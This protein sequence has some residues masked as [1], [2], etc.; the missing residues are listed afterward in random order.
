[1]RFNHR[2]LG[3]AVA[4]A[5]AQA[6]ASA[7]T[8]LYVQAPQSGA[9]YTS[10]VYN[11]PGDPGF[12]WSLPMD[13]EAWAYFR[14]PSSGSFDRITWFGSD[15]DGEFAVNFYGATCFSCG[16]NLV[17]TDGGF[18][19]SLLPEPG[20]FAPAQVN[21]TQ[22]APG[23]F[24]Y[25]IDLSAPLT[26]DAGT[27]LYALSVVNNYSSLPFQWAPSASGL[28]SHVRFI[29][30]MHM[31]QAAPGNLAF[32]LINTAAPVPEPATRALLGL[33][34]LA[35]VWRTARRRVP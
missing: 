15:A 20:P 29:D 8:D 34:L 12:S 22:L 33:G 18:T 9:G 19:N 4:L 35:V 16:V 23:L 27:P 10:A 13:Q 11:L 1:M 28:G 17:R 32:S 2:L 3:V 7:A 21:K 31:V 26:L 24:S 30:G 14:P 6:T 25:S 5:A